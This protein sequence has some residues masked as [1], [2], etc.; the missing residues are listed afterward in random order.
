[1]SNSS[2][3]CRVENH[4]LRE[5]AAE[6]GDNYFKNVNQAELKAMKEEQIRLE[7]EIKK[8]KQIE[9]LNRKLE[10]NLKAQKISNKERTEEIK[11]L[12]QEKKA[13]A[14]KIKEYNKKIRVLVEK[15]RQF[16][17]ILSN[18][19]GTK[20]NPVSSVL[21]VS[22]NPTSP[23]FNSVGLKN[24]QTFSFNESLPKVDNY[25]EEQPMLFQTKPLKEKEFNQNLNLNNNKAF[26]EI[27]PQTNQEIN[28]KSSG[29]F[30]E[31]IK[32]S[33]MSNTNVVNIRDRIFNSIKEKINS[34]IIP[35]QPPE[36]RN[37]PV[38]R[39]IQNQGSSLSNINDELR[40]NVDN[41]K[42]FRKHG[43]ITNETNYVRDNSINKFNTNNKI[44]SEEVRNYEKK[45]SDVE[46]KYIKQNELEKRR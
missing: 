13:K 5:K 31:E 14:E 36:N 25:K 34:E 15:P 30:S 9:D 17:N 21:P 4:F 10:D 3:N 12:E 32:H 22:D 43:V 29:I 40:K 42:E 24:Y 27:S 28:K 37:K 33:N 8:R 20:N 35:S 46:E 16:D 26:I 45:S 2:V 18:L 1:M 19:N 41:V 44:D 7:E 39:N 38:V 23:K 6:Y 11:K